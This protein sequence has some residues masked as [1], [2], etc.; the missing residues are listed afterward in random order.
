MRTH[1]TNFALA[2]VLGTLCFSCAFGRTQTGVS[3]APEKYLMS[4][5]TRVPSSMPQGHQEVQEPVMPALY[6][7]DGSPVSTQRGGTVDPD[8]RPTHDIDSPDGSRM[9][10]L[11]LYQEAIDSKESL[12]LE[13][14][15]LNAALDKANDVISQN[16]GRITELQALLESM[17]ADVIRLQ[18]EGDDLASR[19]TTAQIRRLEAEKLLLEAKLEWRRLQKMMEQRV[20]D[21]EGTQSGGQR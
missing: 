3:S 14:E 16:E 6:G 17:R 7:R 13:V 18:A 5:G 9:Y 20:E 8:R 21:M 2:A 12:E 15:A 11:E 1:V 19:L 4:A 10:I